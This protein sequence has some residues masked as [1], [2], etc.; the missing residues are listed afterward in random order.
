M[1]RISVAASHV[2]LVCVEPSYITETEYRVMH[3][4]DS[5]VVADCE[6]DPWPDRQP[7]QELLEHS[8][9]QKAGHRKARCRDGRSC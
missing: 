2:C 8:L 3:I 5:Q 1:Y 9:E 7:G 4:S 6:T